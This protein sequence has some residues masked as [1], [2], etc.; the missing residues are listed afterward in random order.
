MPKVK[1]S[2]ALIYPEPLGPLRPV[3]EHLYF[4]FYS[5]VKQISDSLNVTMAVAMTGYGHSKL[6]AC[7]KLQVFALRDLS[8]GM[9]QNWGLGW[10][11]G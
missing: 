5:L 8:M 7:T 6:Q 4:Y 3:A 11:S 2:G 1:K 10:R 9:S